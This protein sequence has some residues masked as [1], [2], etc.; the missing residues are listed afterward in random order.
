MSQSATPQFQPANELGDD[1]ITCIRRAL[2]E[3]IGAGDVTTDVIVATAA[4]GGAEIIARQTGV[5]SG[6]AVAEAVF[7]LLSSDV[8]VSQLFRWRF[9]DLG[10]N[11]T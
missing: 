3:D 11:P 2:E 1:I 10:T 6:L 8:S 9:R 5:V 7:R 4:R